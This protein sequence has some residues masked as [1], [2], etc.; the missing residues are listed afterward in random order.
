MALWTCPDGGGYWIAVDQLAPL[1]MFHLFDRMT[2]EPRGSFT[3][4]VTAHTDGIAL[5][6]ARD[7]ALSRAARCSPCTTT[8][9]WRRSTC[10]TSCDAL[11][12][13]PGLPARE[14]MRDLLAM[15]RAARA[16]RAAGLAPP[17]TRRKVYRWTDRNG[18]VHYGD[19]V[20]DDA[21]PTRRSR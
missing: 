20:A 21:S 7:R 8:R 11:H 9:P 4:D 6:A 2:L 16:R 5:H 15:A 1:T 10:A 18:I 19:H 14:R 17:R 12:L 3:G 13:D